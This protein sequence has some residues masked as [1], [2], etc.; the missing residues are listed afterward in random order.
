[1]IAKW[2]E[3]MPVLTASNVYK[4]GVGLTGMPCSCLGTWARV[5]L[6]DDARGW[7]HADQGTPKHP[8]Y[9]YLRNA[10]VRRGVW[11]KKGIATTNDGPA[12]KKLLAEAWNEAV[13]KAG[14]TEDVV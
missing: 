13:T 9:R 14:Y 6:K 4:G 10:L 5:V 2:P 12:S 1:M 7:Y 3:E 11:D 8:F